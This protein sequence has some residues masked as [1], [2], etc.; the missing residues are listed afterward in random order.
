MGLKIQKSFCHRD[1]REKQS[2]KSSSQK[3]LCAAANLHLL[4]QEVN[5]SLVVLFLF[6]VNINDGNFIINRFEVGVNNRIL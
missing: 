6:I 3:T 5:S 4:T 1:H 2:F